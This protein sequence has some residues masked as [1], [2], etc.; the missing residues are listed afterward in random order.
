MTFEHLKSHAIHKI[1]QILCLNYVFIKYFGDFG[2]VFSY[3]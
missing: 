3:K 1:Q 2:Y